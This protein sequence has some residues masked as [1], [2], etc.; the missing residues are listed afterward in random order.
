MS[1][2]PSPWIAVAASRDIGARPQRILFDGRPLVLFRSG[3]AVRALLD[4]C[5]HRAA[6][7]SGGRVVE[8]MIEC[9]YHGWRFDGDGRCKL[10]PGLVGDLP[11]AQVPTY[12]V[13]EAEGLVFV[14]RDRTEAAPYASVLAGS[15]AVSTIVRSRVASTLA[16]VAE[17]IL[18]AT[19]THTIHKGI[20]RGL[21]ARR[22]RVTVTVTGGDGWVEARYE[23]DARQ[24]G[25]ISRLLEG[26]RTVSVGRFLAP[27]IAELE[28][29]GA[30]QI[31]LATTFHLREAG[32]G[33][34][35]GLALLS[36]PRQK[37]LGVL[38]AAL[39]RPLFAI[40]VGQDRRIL[41]RAQSNRLLVGDQRPM[42]T[43]LDVMRPHIDAI[44]AG[45]R[46]TV[47]D[48]PQVLQMD[49]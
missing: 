44:L 17:N 6:P 19:H 28:F 14:A 3:G 13:A 16:E 25:L 39:F 35:T 37:G 43:P 36:G 15:D 1:P 38:K 32:D 48:R 7:L 49:L 21:S 20:L 41:E 18:D 26:G 11:R 10:M 34:V 23:G 9:P 31:N 8:G 30:R 45:Q 40:A 47:A 27:G 42:L 46:P 4:H 2:V 33:K 24:E 22:Y 29:W 12:P 5:P